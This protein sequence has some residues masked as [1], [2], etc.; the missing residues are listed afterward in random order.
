MPF[1][2]GSVRA[3]MVR[4]IAGHATAAERLAIELHLA[5]CD[6]CVSE[7]AAL[8]GVRRMQ[9]WEPPPLS[10]PAR[11]R[12]RRTTLEQAIIVPRRRRGRDWRY[13][14]AAVIAA[15]TT[16]AAYFVR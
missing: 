13:V 6:E 3:S 8:E 16:V 7:R 12:T 2:C 14:G 5:E 10:E 15:A 4:S 1:A 9:R 11:E